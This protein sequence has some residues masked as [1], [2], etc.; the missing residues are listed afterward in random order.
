MNAP[1]VQA[2]L[3]EVEPPYDAY[4][5]TE[6]A[7]QQYPQLAAKNEGLKMPEVTKTV[8]LADAYAGTTQLAARLRLLAKGP[9]Y[10]QEF[11]WCSARPSRLG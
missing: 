8:A 4:W 2:V 7:L 9:P 3:D 11:L 1:D 6:A 10:P 5:R